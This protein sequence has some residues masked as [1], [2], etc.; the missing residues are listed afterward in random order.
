[1]SPQDTISGWQLDA[2]G[3]ESYE[4]ELVPLFFGPWAEE[5]VA[6]AGVREGDHVLDAACGTGA[7]ARHAAAIVGP[8]G[9]VTAVDVSP[10]MLAVARRSAQL[11]EP[12]AFELADVT[13]IP[14]ADV[15]M[16][17]VLC[18]QGLQY[19][20][21]R[22]AALRELHRVTRPGGRLAVSTCR[23]LDHQP[24]YRILTEALRY[25]V[26][27]EASAIIAS[28]YGLGDP[29]ELGSLLRGSGW[30]DVEVRIRVTAIRFDD[31]DRFLA[32]ET[33][34]SPLG[35]IVDRLDP[36]VRDALTSDLTAALAPHTDDG[37][38]TFPFETLLATAIR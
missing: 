17:A 16:D 1:M 37:G 33:G 3:A 23:G 28:P 13:D 2:A 29:G 22:A 6:A 11:D 10:A 36:D 30:N 38:I 34:S 18:Q 20:P 27:A 24:A 15:A 12:I 7:V 8:L 25:H 21:D 32:A 31:P 19:F 9:S 5:L 35:I 14:L 26:G 4:R